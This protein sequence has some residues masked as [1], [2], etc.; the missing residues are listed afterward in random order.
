MITTSQLTLLSKKLNITQSVILRE[1]LQILFLSMLY[2]QK[3]SSSIF[4]KG[5]TAI[6]LIYKAPRFSEDMDFTV[7]M[8]EKDFLV[9]IR[10][11]VKKLSQ[12]ETIGFKERKTI[13]GKRFLLT[14]K[15]G[16]MPY[17]I[18]INLD[19]SFREKVLIKEKSIIETDYPVLFTSYI[20]HLSKE[21][22]F[23]EKIRA[24][25]S[26]KKGR[27]LYDLWYLSTLGI[28]PTMRM[29]QKKL[30]YYGLELDG[31]DP[32]E[33]SLG[34]FTE[35]DFVRDL[36]PFVPIK[37]R[38]DLPRLFSYITSYLRASLVKN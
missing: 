2:Q 31:K 15:P 17:D 25:T 14:L 23:A 36:Q 37:E 10:D 26:R 4:F 34:K 38:H 30:K 7:N 24:L 12:Q 1:Y 29:I 13:T 32:L 11:T 27:D 9:L 8:D 6:H 20:H 18:F 3:K 28:N 22:L 19:F 16:V 35:K 33:K 21:E 5:G